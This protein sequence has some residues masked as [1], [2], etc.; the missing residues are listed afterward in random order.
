MV[1]TF[2][3]TVADLECLPEDGNRYELID[4]ELYV[5]K[6]PG[7]K[8]QRAVTKL[9]FLLEGYTE[10]TGRGIVTVGPGIIFD[11]YNGV[12]PDLVYVSPE[13]QHLIT[14]RGLTG[15]PD[16]A[17]EVLSPGAKNIERDR[18]IKLQLY[19]RQGVLEYWV[20]DPEGETVEIYRLQENELVLVADLQKTDTLT[21]PLLPGFSCQVAEIF[22]R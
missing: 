16:L 5:S 2:K 15:A 11:D 21:S 9:G 7:W 1:T 18:R 13:R 8:H 19:S 17:I 14:E 10:E 12:I 22:A 4:G 20:V 3:L 6:A